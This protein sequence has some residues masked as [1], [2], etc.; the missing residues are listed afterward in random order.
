MRLTP[1]KTGND[2][3][4]AR[5]LKI[6]Q[7][8]QTDHR[9]IAGIIASICILMLPACASRLEPISL[10]PEYA[11]APSTSGLWLELDAIRDDNWHYLLNQGVPAL[12]WRLRAIDSATRSI[13]LQSLFW[14]FDTTGRLIL[15]H[16][17]AAADR[18]VRVRVLVDDMFMVSVDQILLGLH[19]HPNIE[20]RT[21]NPYRRRANGMAT[22]EILNLGEFHRLDHRMHNKVM[23]ID[24]RISIIGGRNL[25]DEYFGLHESANFRDMETISGGPVVSTIS[26]AFDRFWNNQW[27]FPADALITSE[28]PANSLEAARSLG[29]TDDSV[30]QEESEQARAQQ[31]K[32]VVR[33]SVLGSADLIMDDPPADNPADSQD[34]PV[35]MESDIIDLVDSAKEEIW[36]VSA[37]LI[38]T[39]EFAAAIQRAEER[40]VEI[41][42][43]TNSIQSNNHLTAHSAYR[44]H[45]RQLMKYGADLHEVRADAKDRAIYMQGP[46]DDKKLGLHAKVM[47]VDNES[48]LIGSANLDPRS[49]RLNT[50]IGLLINSPAFARQ[51]RE[52]FSLDFLQ[53]NAWSLRFAEGGH[54]QWV[55]DDQVLDSQPAQSYMQR[56]EDWFFALLPIEGET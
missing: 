1:E 16:V 38:P 13:D 49:F 43:L 20:F 14:H 24:N 25:A 53:R 40:G 44:N 12:D 2:N 41:R 39:T 19:T 10:P 21:F 35:Q 11:S 32:M 8:M 51:V 47:V 56:I 46:V 22:Q 18:G 34:A 23:V 50:E 26:D 3:E 33:Q 9:T 54:V 42:L 4:P 27:A 55:S 15:K 45:I 52:A 28:S 31:W 7:D 37:Y 36:M 30:H 29:L 48:V 5:R 17:L 6:N